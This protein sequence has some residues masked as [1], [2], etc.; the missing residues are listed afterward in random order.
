MRL[1]Y[2]IGKRFAFSNQKFSFIKT[3][4]I[5]SSAGITIG[6][7]SLIIMISVFNGFEKVVTDIMLG[8]DP[9]MRFENKRKATIEDENKLYDELSKNKS[10]KGVSKTISGK[11]LLVHGNNSTVTYL[12]GFEENKINII[13]GI[14]NSIYDGKGSIVNN[15]IIIS[16]GVANKLNLNVGDELKIYSTNN[17][18]EK[19]LF[20]FTDNISIVK[21]SAIFR[22][23]NKQYDENYI[24]SNINYADNIFDK[25]GNKGIDLRL[26]NYNNTENLKSELLE[27]Y[28]SNFEIF[29]WQDLH[30]DLY[31]IMKIEK[32][33]AFI[34]LLLII[35]IAVCNLIGSI[36]MTVV[37][38]IND[39]GLLQAIGMEKKKIKNIFQFQGFYIGFIGTIAGLIIGV[40]VC[41]FQ[42]VFQFYKLDETVYIIPAIPI[43]LRMTDVLIICTISISLSVAASIIPSKKIMKILPIEAL[44]YE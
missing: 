22:S 19:Y 44:R 18:N 30:R 43:D 17:L 4:S 5:I 36:S 31:S 34:I 42:T 3:L 39:I 38:K 28:N 14:D 16:V 20:G 2:F 1:S 29:T 8:F 27:K 6:V 37:S 12:R 23:G 41:Y 35:I 26:N 7:A 24:F 33:I 40:L 9:H 25:N 32:F 21:I 13:S 11:V 15:E 10:I